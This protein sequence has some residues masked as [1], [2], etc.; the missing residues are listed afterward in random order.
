MFKEAIDGAADS[1]KLNPSGVKPVREKCKC[2]DLV[3]SASTSIGTRSPIMQ[4]LSKSIADKIEFDTPEI[5]PQESLKQVELNRTPISEKQADRSQVVTEK[6]SGKSI[7][8]SDK[9]SPVYLPILNTVSETTKKILDILEKVF[10]KSDS[11]KSIE[12]DINKSRVFDMPKVFGTSKSINYSEL[13]VPNRVNLA[14]PALSDI[15]PKVST[16]FTK[17]ILD[18]IKT[19]ESVESSDKANTLPESIKEFTE[20]NITSKISNVFKFP[21]KPVSL[22]KVTPTQTNNKIDFSQKPVDFAKQIIENNSATISKTGY[23]FSDTLKEPVSLDKVTPTQTNTVNTLKEPV[24]EKSITQKTSRIDL[25]KKI[26]II[27]SLTEPIKNILAKFSSLPPIKELEN[28]QED[29]KE[30]DMPTPEAAKK[31]SGSDLISSGIDLATNLKNVIPAPTTVAKNAATGV[32]LTKSVVESG[33]AASYIPR[34]MGLANTATGAIGSSLMSVGSSAMGALSGIGSTLA[35]AASTLAPVAGVAAAG[36]GGYM[37][38]KHVINPLIDK[39]L[40][41]L[42]GEKTDLGSWLYDKMNPETAQKLK[43]SS[44]TSLTHTPEQIAEFNKTKNS[45]IEAAKTNQ[46]NDIVPLIAAQQNQAS[47]IQQMSTIRDAQSAQQSQQQSSGGNSGN[48]ATPNANNN[49]SAKPAPAQST[50]MMVTPSVRN[51]DSTFERVQMQ[52]F[53]PRVY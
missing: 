51:Q 10:K 44:T 2:E 19:K 16:D 6:T 50:K 31:D 29:N 46:Q 47:Q 34:L 53:W 4:D 1:I 38:G 13:F 49:N 45:Q 18:S 7:Q 9:E 52:D 30:K 20:K 5:A 32:N 48:N 25:L 39:G 27:K 33:K 35:G 40:S 14:K 28:A 41:S 3:K 15:E 11:R 17:T 8:N 24:L 21:E 12:E 22:D 26:P 36:V 37:L 43:E 23:N 42:T